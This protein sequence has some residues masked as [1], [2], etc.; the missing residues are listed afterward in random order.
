MYTPLLVRVVPNNLYRADTV[1]ANILCLNGNGE[2]VAE[3]CVN[4][5]GTEKKMNNFTRKR[6]V[7]TIAM[8][9]LILMAGCG[10]TV[11][12][13]QGNLIET[14]V[15]ESQMSRNLQAQSAFRAQRF[16]EAAQLFTAQAQTGGKEEH[17]AWFNAGA[18]YWNAGDKRQAL[19][20]YEQAV[21]VNPLYLK[22][23][24]RLTNKYALLKRAEP[25]AKHKKYAVTIQG[26]TKK[27]LPM[28]D[29]ANAMR[30][31]GKD[32]YEAAAVIHEASAEFY[33]QQGFQDCAEAERKLA[34][35]SRMEGQAALVKFAIAK[36]DATSEASQAAFRTEVVGTVK[37]LTATF[38]RADA[39]T[40]FGFGA[41]GS[42]SAKTAVAGLGVLESSLSGYAGMMQAFEG[43]IQEQRE[44]MR[45]QGQQ[46]QAAL[47]DSTQAQTQRSAQQRTM[48][49]QKKIEQMEQ[50]AKAML[51]EQ[52][53][54]EDGD[55][56]GDRDTLDL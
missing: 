54:L 42:S 4:V 30:A 46:A 10:G 7:P 11:S 2:A 50:M 45:Q 16:D 41:G 31:Q 13:G 36:Q 1:W 48:E 9:P 47:A 14:T 51:A 18:S 56:T 21:A 20:A 6:G 15:A 25:S 5:S 24:L 23:H 43:R 3:N 40:P 37:D 55:V 27:M 34:D 17:K 29:Q 28:W 49:L 38:T 35:H 33:A 12:Q 26:V 52:G 22:G 8:I 44:T 19:E 53:L 39:T 32:W